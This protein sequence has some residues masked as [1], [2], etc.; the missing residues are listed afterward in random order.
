MNLL[1]NAQLSFLK[2]VYILPV[3]SR[4]RL[5]KKNAKF[6]ELNHNTPEMNDV[7]YALLAALVDE[8]NANLF[9]EV[10]AHIIG[11]SISALA[12][13]H[14]GSHYYKT[15]DVQEHIH[16]EA[17]IEVPISI[18]RAVLK[19][20]ALEKGDVQIEFC[21]AKGNTFRI[22][23]S[24]DASKR[25]RVVQKAQ[26]LQNKK[27]ELEVLFDVYLERQGVVS[28]MRIVDFLYSNMEEAL[29]YMK[30]ERSHIN[31]RYI[32]VARF[33][34]YIRQNNL[35]MYDVVCDIS[36]GAMVAGLLR[37]KDQF[38]R[39]KGVEK[40]EYF[41]D[42][43]IVLGILDLSREFNVAQARDLL[44]VIKS[45]N[46]VARIHSLTL[47]EIDSILYTVKNDGYPCR[48][49]ELSEA[50]SR[51]HLKPSDIVRIKSRLKQLILENGIEV[52]ESSKDQSDWMKSASI[53]S[54]AGELARVRGA[55]R[56]DDFRELHD[57]CVWKYVDRCN[58]LM[59]HANPT[60]TYFVTS[61]SD[62]IRFIDGK[63]D[64]QEESCLLRTDNLVVNLWLRG[65]FNLDMKKELLSEK[66][67]KCL[68]ANE[69]DTTRRVGAVISHYRMSDPVTA[70]ETSAMFE[71]LADRPSSFLEL[72]DRVLQEK[73]GDSDAISKAV[74]IA[75]AK[76]VNKKRK[77]LGDE[78]WAKKEDELKE[79]ALS[80]QRELEGEKQ[81]AIEENSRLKKEI[82]LRK[83]LDAKRKEIEECDAELAPL[84]VEHDSCAG[85]SRYYIV[86]VLHVLGLL[87]SLLL[88]V[89]LLR[90]WWVVGWLQTW[91][92][93]KSNW[94]SLI[95]V[96]IL[97]LPC[98]WFPKKI[99]CLLG[100]ISPK[101][102]EKY[103]REKQ[104][105]WEQYNPR[106]KELCEKRGRLTEE[107]R[108]IED[109][110][111]LL[112]R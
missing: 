107:S 18:I 19:V 93:I 108:L 78:E 49:N 5:F 60:R 56:E 90:S 66:I 97:I 68:V 58:K 112:V 53:R 111:S 48:S 51:R 96:I 105:E 10:F 83:D 81:R 89:G 30:G 80:R 24:W 77:R 63:R 46:G 94:S 2:W 71:A 57:I 40:V 86:R 21:G 61:N 72:L 79:A 76:E 34:E 17:G 20:K 29:A 41:L 110:L 87:V 33:I 98:L 8:Q 67:S 22:K 85:R 43:P 55:E 101:K 103:K 3:F 11:Y 13:R 69:V 27:T 35:E 28:Q 64:P 44:R 42:T 84:Q 9:D 7:N 15:T 38:K 39:V 102:W 109:E 26:N 104:Q 74:L 70:E 100:A 25:T 16:E 12:E 92:W 23:R 95:P 65:G 91:M 37:G 54:L 36:W 50:Y 99:D 106:Y 6:V 31:E 14:E 47:K 73:D 45:N 52:G 75:N 88:V 4:I 82:R 62:F 59:D 1:E 32:H